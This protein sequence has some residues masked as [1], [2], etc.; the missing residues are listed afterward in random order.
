MVLHVQLWISRSHD[1]TKTNHTTSLKYLIRNELKQAFGGWLNIMI[2]LILA[3]LSCQHLLRNCWANQSQISCGAAVRW[4]IK[5]L[6]K[7]SW[8]YDQ[9]IFFSETSRPM[10]FKLGI[11]HWRLESHKVCSNDDPGLTLTYFTARSTL[12]P[13][14]FVWENA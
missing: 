10:A 8:S 4:G 12:L 13:Y 9:E 5:S 3:H 11:Q 6:F 1:H 14:A 7:W 2:S